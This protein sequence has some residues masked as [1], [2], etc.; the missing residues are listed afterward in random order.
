MR[1]AM[2][3]ATL[4]LL[5]IAGTWVSGIGALLAVGVSLHLARR[6]TAVELAVE[7][8]HRV[9]IAPGEPEMPEYI[10]VLVVNL[11]QQPV[12]ITNVGW[13][14]GLFRK[15][16]AIQ[17]LHGIPLSRVPPVELT[18]GQ[19]A[20]FL[21]P[22]DNTNWLKDMARRLDGPFPGLSAWMMRVQI[23]TSVGKTITRRL[24]S[25]LRK[26]LVEAHAGIIK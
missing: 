17:M 15:R 3:E 7:A 2:D 5:E 26:K 10:S 8:G 19:Q 11:G 23:F 4:R 24:E 13:R 20:T 21:V 14:F 1:F 22:L 16:Y 18:T 25:G 6:Q 9:I 12:T